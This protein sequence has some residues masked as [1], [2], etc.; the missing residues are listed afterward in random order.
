VCKNDEWQ[1]CLSTISTTISPE[2]FPERL[3]R[4]IDDF[5]APPYMAD[6]ARLELA[7]HHCQGFQGDR[8]TTDDGGLSLNPSLA[9]LD[10]EWSGLSAVVENP[11]YAISDPPQ[12]HSEMVMVWKHA[13]SGS[14]RYRKA[15]HNDL[16]SI[17]I[18]LEEIDPET[19]AAEGG[20]SIGFID[21][22]INQSVQHGIILRAPSKL[23]RDAKLSDQIDLDVDKYLS[24]SVFTLQWHITQACDLHCKHCYDRSNRSPLKLEQGFKV[25][26][27]LRAFCV[28]NNI[29]GQVSFTGGN[30]LLYPHFIDLYEAASDRG[31]MLAI[32]GNPT[33]PEKLD[34]L[35]A[36]QKPEFF[37]VS[38][39]GLPEHNDDIRGSG[40]F[41]R[42]IDFLEILENKKV[43]SM[44]MLTL[45]A[46]NYEQVLPLGEILRGKTDLF[47]FNRLTLFGEGANLKPVPVDVYNDLLLSYQKASEG[48]SV[49][50]FKDNLF[51]RIRLDGSLPIFGGCAG[52]G[53][54]AAFNFV[55]VL[56]DGEVHAC[57]K[58]PSLIGN[59]FQ[60]TLGE[61][62]YSQKAEQY[63]RGTEACR[64]CSLEIVCRGCP[65][66]VAGHGLDPKVDRDP[67][68]A[69]P[70]YLP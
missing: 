33:T 45:T 46:S 17:K 44:I 26:D 59:I 60:S 41:K 64:G 55:A 32:L 5:S 24:P 63:R 53:C 30:P 20:V 34:E 15:Q 47:N 51:N 36:I 68:C 1:R 69:G 37:Q 57:R 40:H 54:G 56:P 28:R 65:A 12:P 52:Y 4:C 49:L 25:L 70:V 67:Y 35:L 22:I 31:F 23:R 3:A 39:E 66:V 10:L 29:K 6:L 19:A 11:S 38:L 42:V 16:L 43:Y 9:L 48:N 14:V 50:G 8:L 61:I 21:N 58:F 62:Y 2:D 27:D 18:I 13:E 7:V